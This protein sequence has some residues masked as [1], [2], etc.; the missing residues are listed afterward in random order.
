MAQ[1]QV[2]PVPLRIETTGFICM[3]E[4]LASWNLDENTAKHYIY[5]AA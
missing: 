4:T 2:V 5:S 3:Y 1:T